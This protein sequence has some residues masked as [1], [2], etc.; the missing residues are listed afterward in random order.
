MG[1]LNTLSLLAF[2]FIPPGCHW[3]D[4]AAMAVFGVSIGALICYLGGL[5]AVDLVSPKAAGAALGVVGIA[6]YIG[7]GTQDVLSGYLI[8]G[9]KT[10]VGPTSGYNFTPLAVFWLIA[11]LMS[12]LMTVA[13]WRTSRRARLSV[14]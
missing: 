7:A 6:S 4:V 11:S 5:M 14:S 13:T 3:F 10:G 8:D 12:V 2:V 1:A 9:F